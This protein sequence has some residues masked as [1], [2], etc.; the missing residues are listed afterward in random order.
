MG[1][2]AVSCRRCRH[3]C[4]CCCCCCCC[5]LGLGK[6]AQG[7]IM[8]SAMKLQPM[9]HYCYFTIVP[10]MS[11]TDQIVI[12]MIYGLPSPLKLPSLNICISA[13]PVHLFHNTQ[14]YILHY[15]FRLLFSQPVSPALLTE[16]S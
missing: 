3:C 14:I 5:L 16:L 1:S 8:H 11:K 6:A 12:Y 13:R 2:D 4:Y 15:I 7:I 10:T 9:S